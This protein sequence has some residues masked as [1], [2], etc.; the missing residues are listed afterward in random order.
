MLIRGRSWTSSV[1]LLR[2][3]TDTTAS[4]TFLLTPII[5]RQLKKW[6]L[7]NSVTLTRSSTGSKNFFLNNFPFIK[8]LFLSLCF[9]III[10]NFFL[11]NLM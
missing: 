1:V 9:F 3:M 11:T 7:K 8:F 5:I 10:I 6:D 2:Q 4:K